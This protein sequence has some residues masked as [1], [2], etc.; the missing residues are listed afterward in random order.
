[1][2]FSENHKETQRFSIFQKKN[3]LATT[4][5][6]KATEMFFSFLFSIFGFFVLFLFMAMENFVSVEVVVFFFGWLI[7][8]FCC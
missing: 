1:M 8:F 5:E 3:V 6:E 2:F 7:G 4:E